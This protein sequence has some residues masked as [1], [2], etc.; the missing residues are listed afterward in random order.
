M[1]VPGALLLIAFLAPA[2]YGRQAQSTN[3]SS[4]GSPTVIVQDGG[5]DQVLQSVYIPPIP[6]APFIAIVHTQW[7]RPLMDGGTYT[8]VNQRQ[9]ARDRSGRIYEERW[10]LVPKDG[11]W[12]SRMNLIQIAD[13][14]THT[15]YNCFLL[16]TPHR[17]AAG[18]YDD[19]PTAHYQPPVAQTGALLN[20][21]GFQTHEDL[22]T[23]TIAGVDVQGTRD[24]ITYNQGVIGKDRPFSRTRAFWYAPSLGID[25]ESELSAPEFGKEIF[26][27]TDVSTS[28]P[29]P[30]LFQIPDGFQVV[31]HRR[32][33]A[34]SGTQ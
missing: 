29:D 21:D 3:Q 27:L 8:V 24:S 26:T 7:I 25:L 17:C 14:S 10:L 23:Q 11:K 5:V 31:D 2:L 22:G 19:S 32:P 28:D 30:K 16:E 4:S 9:V 34:Q 6:N 33:A 18:P 12:K 15:L 1:R 13:P 20:G